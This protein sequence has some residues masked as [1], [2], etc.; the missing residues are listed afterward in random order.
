[1]VR[2]VIA[3]YVCVVCAECDG[4]R[5]KGFVFCG[6][7]GIGLMKHFGAE[8]ACWAHN[9][10]VVGSRPTSAMF[11]SSYY[12]LGDFLLLIGLPIDRVLCCVM[13]RMVVRV[14]WAVNRR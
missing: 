13:E 1:M 7:F 10:K 11:C 9:P 12:R 14:V 3:R 6:G 5:T 4:R 2:R 8:V